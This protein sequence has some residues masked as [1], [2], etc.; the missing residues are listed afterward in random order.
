[1]V[2]D[3]ELWERGCWWRSMYWKNQMNERSKKILNMDGRHDRRG[4]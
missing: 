1:M 3:V 2:D 4:Q